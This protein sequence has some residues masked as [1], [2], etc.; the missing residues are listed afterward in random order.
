MEVLGHLRDKYISLNKE[1]FFNSRTSSNTTAL[2]AKQFKG[3]CRECGE[4][5]HKK[6]ECPRIK[7]NNKNHKKTPKKK[8]GKNLICF[9]CVKKGH[10][11]RD[12]FKRKRDAEQGI[13]EPMFKEETSKIVYRLILSDTSKN[14]L[15]PKKKKDG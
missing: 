3:Y 12:C 9:Y 6:A 5:G 14:F 1:I 11:E 2:F 13:V 4:Y 15:N 7:K 8:F 10:I